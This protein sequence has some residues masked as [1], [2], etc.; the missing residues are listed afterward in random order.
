MA[1]QNLIQL[2]ETETASPDDI[3]YIVTN[4][5]AS[6]ADRKIQARNLLIGAGGSELLTADRIYYVRKDGSDSNDGLTDSAGGAFLTI[7]RAVQA[8]YQLNMNTYDVT[9]K[10]GPGTYTEKVVF[11]SAMVGEG[12]VIVEGTTTGPYQTIIHDTDNVTTVGTLYAERCTVTFRKLK[13]YTSKYGVHSNEYGHI[14]TQEMEVHPYSGGDYPDAWRAENGGLLTMSY[15]NYIYESVAT[16]GSGIFMAGVRAITNGHVDGNEPVIAGTPLFFDGVFYAQYDSS[17]IQQNFISGSYTIV[18]SGPAVQCLVGSHIQV[19]M[20]LAS[21]TNYT[22]DYT[23][24]FKDTRNS[25]T[26]SPIRLVLGSDFSITSSTVL[27]DIT[28]LKGSIGDSGDKYRVR[29]KLFTTS[30]ASGG[31]KAS[32]GGTASVVSLLS[33]YTGTIQYGTS[34]AYTNA[35]TLG[36]ALVGTTAV[37]DAI[38]TI[39]GVLTSNSFGTITVQFAQNASFGTASVVKAGSYLEIIRMEYP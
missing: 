14:Y 25:F 6:P 26:H 15:A 10:V 39:E 28:G 18:S 16:T 9:V 20:S 29:A 23:S 21:V 37:T 31:V 7:S 22:C 33:Y 30:N 38:I 27:T 2:T 1:D 11:S 8:I 3:L 4:P 32:L 5:G 19:G 36:T 34:T 13:V 35:T 24:I 17:I 12:T